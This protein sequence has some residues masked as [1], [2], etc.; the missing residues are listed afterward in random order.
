MAVSKGGIIHRDSVIGGRRAQG[1]REGA[2]RAG[3]GQE[4]GGEAG[5][6]VRVFVRVPVGVVGEGDGRKVLEGLGTGGYQWKQIHVR[7]KLNGLRE[8]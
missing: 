2:L 3:V 5:G 6:K 7:Q 4:V 8:G 1:G